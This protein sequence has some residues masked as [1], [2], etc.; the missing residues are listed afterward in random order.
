M[1]PDR[2]ALFLR[3]LMLVTVL[4]V[5]VFAF[6]QSYTHIFHL[7]QTHHESGA[8]LRMIPLSV[9]WLI[10]AAGL[11][12][13]N[14]SRK[15][16]KPPLPK[17]ILWIGIIATLFGNVAALIIYGPVATIIGAWAPV[18]LVLTVEM[19]MYLVRSAAKPEA[20][21][22]KPDGIIQFNGEL[23]AEQVDR[24]REDFLKAVAEGKATELRQPPEPSPAPSPVADTGVIPEVTSPGEALQGWGQPGGQQAAGRRLT[25]IGLA[26]GRKG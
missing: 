3:W 23:T 22:D 9:D 5:A 14:E 26:N 8:A 20:K 11:V 6:T 7:A 1:P 4:A 21:E 2:F 24:L 16:L 10:L 17:F 15:G 19:G 18:C 12:L 13:L 25:G